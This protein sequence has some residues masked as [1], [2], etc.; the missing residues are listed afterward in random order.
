MQI[1]SKIDKLIVE[2]NNLKPE[3]SDDFQKNEKKFTELLRSSIEA[4]IKNSGSLVE[5]EPSPLSKVENGIPSWVDQDYGYD[6]QNPRK[7]NMREMMEA[8]SGKAVE[9]LYTETD[10]SW[11]K[12]SRQA[13]D[14][15]YGVVGSH[16]DTRDWLSIM[17][18]KD[19]LT[20]AR[21]QTG[22]MYEPELD[23]RSNFNQNGTLTEQIAIIKDSK[24][25]TLASLSN[26]ITSAEETLLNFGATKE[27]IPSNLEDQVDLE[28]FDNNLLTFLKNFDKKP[29]SIEQILVQNASEVI[30]NKISQEI[31]LDELAKL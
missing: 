30:A 9:D 3:L 14:I 1:I 5:K 22:A 16:E 6:L 17:E 10:E 18:S 13:S 4:N 2:L 7:P 25:N 28:I 20:K 23:I 27:C 11:E 8:L 29:A 24:G 31:P 12:I 19:V 26:N 15:L 21:E